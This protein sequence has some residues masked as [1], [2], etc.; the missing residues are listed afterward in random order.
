MQ[1]YVRNIQFFKKF[2]NA[3]ILEMN[4]FGKLKLFMFSKSPANGKYYET[5]FFYVILMREMD[6]YISYSPNFI[7]ETCRLLNGNSENVNNGNAE[8]LTNGKTEKLYNRNTEKIQNGKMEKTV[9]G[10]NIKTINRI[11]ENKII[12][13]TNG[14]LNGQREKSHKNGYTVSSKQILEFNLA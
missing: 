5:I 14:L 7:P 3:V 4:Q 11:S 13:H 12:G 10:N 9:N 8:K 6:F 2:P 1:I